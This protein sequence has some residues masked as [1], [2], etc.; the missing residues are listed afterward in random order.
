MEAAAL[1]YGKY[2]YLY[3]EWFKAYENCGREEYSEDEILDMSQRLPADYL[4]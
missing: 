3:Y 2:T 1:N 4:E